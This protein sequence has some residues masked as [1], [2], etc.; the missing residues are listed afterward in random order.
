MYIK[1]KIIKIQLQKM[2]QT[3]LLLQ[4]TYGIIHIINISSL[5]SFFSKGI[6]KALM[7]EDKGEYPVVDIRDRITN[8]F[9]SNDHNKFIIIEVKLLDK[10]MNI[11]FIVDEV[12]RYPMGSSFTAII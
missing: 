1:I 11:G 4:K 2:L 5:M 10:K 12:K 8:S 3:V 9:S 7:I 6:V